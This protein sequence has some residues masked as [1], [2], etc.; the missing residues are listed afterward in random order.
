M[1]TIYTQCVSQTKLSTWLYNS[2]HPVHSVQQHPTTIDNLIYRTGVYAWMCVYICLCVYKM[3]TAMYYDHHR[4]MHVHTATQPAIDIRFVGIRFWESTRIIL[5]YYDVVAAV[6]TNML[7]YCWASVL[8]VRQPHWRFKNCLIHRLLLI[9]LFYSYR[10]C[11][12]RLLCNKHHLQLS[13][14]R[15]PSS[16]FHVN[17]NSKIQNMLVFCFP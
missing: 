1:T 7:L 15:K 10:F 4:R 5:L 2:N 17:I 8:R 11:R 9:I 3:M 6:F 12:L 13:W 16:V 14:Y